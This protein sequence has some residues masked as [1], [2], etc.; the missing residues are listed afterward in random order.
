MVTRMKREE[1]LQGKRVVF[2]RK[3]EV[4]V[5]DFELGNQWTTRCL[6]ELLAP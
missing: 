4:A 2:P 5:E 6:S 1:R 3:G